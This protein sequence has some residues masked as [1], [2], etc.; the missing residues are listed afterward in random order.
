MPNQGDEVVN[1]GRFRTKGGRRGELFPLGLGS[2]SILDDG[3]EIKVCANSSIL[4]CKYAKSQS[5]TKVLLVSEYL[6]PLSFIDAR[7]CEFRIT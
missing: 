6:S 7:P 3:V 2:L 5:G 4:E 1:R